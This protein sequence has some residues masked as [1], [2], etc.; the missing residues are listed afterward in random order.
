GSHAAEHVVIAILPP[1]CRI[2]LLGG[3]GLL[4]DA[5]CFPCECLPIPIIGQPC[6]PRLAMQSF[7]I[8]AWQSSSGVFERSHAAICS[9]RTAIFSRSSFVMGFAIVCGGSAAVATTSMS[10]RAAMATAA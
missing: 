5:A 2:V 7:L 6:S 4:P 8:C 1:L 9:C 10:D 3:Y